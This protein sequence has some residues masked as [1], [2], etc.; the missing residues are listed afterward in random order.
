LP[1]HTFKVNS[2]RRKGKR[3]FHMFNETYSA[4]NDDEETVGK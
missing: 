2:E 1:I 4:E 3:M